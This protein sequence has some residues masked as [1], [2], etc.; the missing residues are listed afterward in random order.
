MLY[1][2]IP[3]ERGQGCIEFTSVTT[4]TSEGFDSRTV[5]QLTELR[6]VQQPLVAIDPSR[7]KKFSRSLVHPARR[8]RVYMRTPVRF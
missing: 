6:G 7:R 2:N 3:L 1:N 4:K 5:Q 8:G